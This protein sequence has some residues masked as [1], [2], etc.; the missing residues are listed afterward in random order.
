M[1]ATELNRLRSVARLVANV[2]LPL[3]TDNCRTLTTRGG[4]FTGGQVLTNYGIG[5]RRT[6]LAGRA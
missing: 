1:S 5:F 3:A 2:V 6:C 4:C